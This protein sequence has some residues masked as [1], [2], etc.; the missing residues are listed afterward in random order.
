MR[1]VESFAD[2]FIA[3]LHAFGR[4]TDE[5]RA[6]VST[7]AK[8]GT[9]DV[10]EEAF[11]ALM[12]RE[13]PLDDMLKRS[14]LDQ[15]KVDA[16]TVA[17]CMDFGGDAEVIASVEGWPDED[18]DAAVVEA[19]FRTWGADSGPFLDGVR[20]KAIRLKVPTRPSPSTNSRPSPRKTTS[21][22]RA[23]ARRTR[24]AA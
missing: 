15:Y 8:D 17:A 7:V 24:R 12:L 18:F 1:Q 22:S 14:V 16:A 3:P 9:V 4:L 20:A 6:S 19:E 23:K 2:S 11:S 10:D 21:S 13:V 5:Q